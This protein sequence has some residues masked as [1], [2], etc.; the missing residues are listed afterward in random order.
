MA[1]PLYSPFDALNFS[2]RNCFLTGATLNS[3]EERIHIFPQWLMTRY[4]LEDKPFKMLD[5]SM[6]T[7]KDLKMTCS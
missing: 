7:Y 5:E 6:A 4:K 1:T 2:N 3:E